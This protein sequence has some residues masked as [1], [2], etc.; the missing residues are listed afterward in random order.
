MLSWSLWVHIV[1]QYC[2]V[3]K[4]LFSQSHQLPLALMIF[5]SPFPWRSWFLRKEVC[6]WAG[7]R[8]LQYVLITCI[9]CFSFWDW[10]DLSLSLSLLP[11]LTSNSLSCSRAPCP[12][13]WNCSLHQPDRLQMIYCV[14]VWG[15]RLWV[16]GQANVHVC[17]IVPHLCRCLQRLKAGFRSYRAIVTGSLGCLMWMLGTKLRSFRRA[18]SMCT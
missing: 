15:G 9:D 14:C 18:V 1:Y 7:V 6:W 11:R 2:F 5:L 10:V 13:Y 12:E 17:A 16:C 4:T 8:I 3:W